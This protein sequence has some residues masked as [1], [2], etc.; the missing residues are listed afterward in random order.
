MLLQ[1]AVRAPDSSD[2]LGLLAAGLRRHLSRLRALSFGSHLL[3]AEEQA[4]DGA[5][6]SLR[7]ALAFFRAASDDPFREEAELLFPRLLERTQGDAELAQG[8][9]TLG[10]DR[11][12]AAALH[13]TIAQTG[14]LL[15]LRQA[16]SQQ[17]S[18]LAEAVEALEA[19]YR[20][21][22]ERLEAQIFP[23]AQSALSE[24]DKRALAEEMFES[25]RATVLPQAEVGPEQPLGAGL[26]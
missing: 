13:Q 8:C 24:A 26:P 9:A 17:V 3:D 5:L 23:R 22:L 25:G 15:V 10:G 2:P 21:H 16:N 6:E 12:R 7:E 18:E 19:L 11:L 14:A 4:R 20:D 1:I